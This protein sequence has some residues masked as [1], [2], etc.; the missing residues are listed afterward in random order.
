MEMMIAV[1]LGVFLIGIGCISFYRISKDF[2][3]MED[4]N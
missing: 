2:K 3:E 1:F 4:K